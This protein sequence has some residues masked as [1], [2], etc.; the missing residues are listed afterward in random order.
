[1][2]AFI[3]SLILGR[4]L[5]SLFI[6]AEEIA[7]IGDV[8]K[9]LLW[10]TVFYF[11][12]ALVNIIRFLIQGI[13][14]PKFAILSGVFEMVARALAGMLLVPV[15]GFTG[16]CLG[17]PI[18]WFFADFFLIPAYFHVSKTL[19]KRIKTTSQSQGV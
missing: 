15:I 3:I 19:R 10:N 11:P 2:I 16:S 4:P 17:G 18:A 1:M 7:I 12:L 9:F 14:F 13:G 6:K 8:Q 5:A